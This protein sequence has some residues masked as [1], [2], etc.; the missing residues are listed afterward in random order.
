MVYD[1]NQFMGSSP[2]I[3]SS[4]I[5]DPQRLRFLTEN[6]AALQGLNYVAM[7]AVVLLSP[8]DGIFNYSKWWQWPTAFVAVLVIWLRYIRKYYRQRF[9]YVEP[10]N[11]SNK[12]IAYLLVAFIVIYIF[13]RDLDRYTL[14]LSQVIRSTISDPGEHVRLL[15]L[16]GWIGALFTSFLKPSLRT[17]E[18]FCFTCLGIIASTGIALYPL[19]HPRATEDLA[20]KTLNAGSLG[21]SLIAMGLYDH[22]TLVRMMPK[23]F[24]E[25]DSE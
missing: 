19:G 7:G 3:G 12:Q 18:R 14:D 6:F 13:R 1:I 24:E 4:P 22:L 8:T 15:P 21:F 2:S 9:G 17:F 23:K 11:P 10:L 25:N 20:W 5:L 16:V